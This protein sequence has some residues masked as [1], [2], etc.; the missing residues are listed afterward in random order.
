M[1]KLKNLYLLALGPSFNFKESCLFCGLACSV[2]R[3]EKHPN[4]W[5]KNPGV[6]CQTGDRGK[7][8]GFKEV[9]L[10]VRIKYK[11]HKNYI[12]FSEPH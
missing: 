4:R 2:D 7:G 9:L 3:D 11:Y 8:K 6:L 12:S 5:G 1:Q 10:D